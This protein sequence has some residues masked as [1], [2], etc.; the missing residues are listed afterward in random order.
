[1]KRILAVI[2]VLGTLSCHAAS[3]QLPEAAKWRVLNQ[4][5]KAIA[6]QQQANDLSNK[7]QIEV[8]AYNALVQKELEAIKAP[9]GYTVQLDLEKDDVSVVPPKAEVKK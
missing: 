8:N 1:M 6:L 5:R 9:K 2:I 4:A 7:A 3:P